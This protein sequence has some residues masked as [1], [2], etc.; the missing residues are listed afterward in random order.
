MEKNQIK[1][2]FAASD[3][4]YDSLDESNIL[5]KSNN[6][7]KSKES[8][9]DDLKDT[10]K[11]KKEEKKIETDPM[12]IQVFTDGS[13]QK[14]GKKE[15]IGGLAAIFVGGVLKGKKLRGKITKN[16][17][18]IRAEGKAI[19]CVLERLQK[20]EE[21]SWSKVQ[22]YS[23]CDFWV[24]MLTKWLFKWTE[25]KF[26]KQKNPDIT[27]KIWQLWNSFPNHIL[28]IIWV[29]AHNKLNWKNS[30]SEYERWCF[31]YNDAVDKLASNAY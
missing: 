11:I 13:C 1:N 9:K 8:I 4:E 25:D 19:I 5:D 16:A 31:K 7:D 24:N 27:K 29:P 20:I 22:I 18:N 12:T 23:D 17:S 26:D 21:K 28:E 14:N 2:E 6:L 30:E 15:A 3:G 10:I